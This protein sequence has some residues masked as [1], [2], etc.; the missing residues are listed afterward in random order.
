ML[1]IT[2]LTF[3]NSDLTTTW[4]SQACYLIKQSLLLNQNNSASRM[5][6]GHQ[7]ARL[8]SQTQAVIAKIG[9]SLKS[10]HHNQ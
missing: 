1:A 4:S 5:L 9:S 6:Q 8:S 10:N 2:D 7:M 3:Y